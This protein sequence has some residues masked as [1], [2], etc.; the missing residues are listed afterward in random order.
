MP[1]VVMRVTDSNDNII[2]DSLPM[3]IS[4]NQVHDTLVHQQQ[5]PDWGFH[6]LLA[7]SWI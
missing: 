2:Y 1:G 3:Y 6:I 7:C 5:D 4:I